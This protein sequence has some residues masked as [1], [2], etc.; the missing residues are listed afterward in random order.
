MI[1]K[2]VKKSSLL[3]NKTHESIKRFKQK[4]YIINP[5]VYKNIQ[6]YKLKNIN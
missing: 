5:K 6:K 3:L 1:K 2:N 4:I